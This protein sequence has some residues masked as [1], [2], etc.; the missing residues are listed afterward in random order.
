MDINE[1][2]P[3]ITPIQLD[4]LAAALER[5]ESIDTDDHR[6][7]VA[8]LYKSYLTPVGQDA[9]GSEVDEDPDPPTFKAYPNLP[10]A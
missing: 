10:R 2:H 9:D 1:P 7:L 8:N 5:G 6:D 4:A 3:D